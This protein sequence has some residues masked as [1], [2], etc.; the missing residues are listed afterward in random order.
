MDINWGFGRVLRIR[1]LR[2]APE[3]KHIFNRVKVETK[4]EKLVRHDNALVL[5]ERRKEMRRTGEDT[6]NIEQAIRDLGFVFEDEP[7]VDDFRY[8]YWRVR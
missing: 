1:F 5:L 8:S 6:A 2:A 4:S 7:G 3:R